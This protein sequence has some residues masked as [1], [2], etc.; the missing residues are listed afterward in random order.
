[1]MPFDLNKYFDSVRQSLFAGTMNQDQVD[2]QQA[3][4]D[5]WA[6]RRAGDDMRWLAYF[7]ATA[8]H[9]TS[10]EM[11]P[12]EE[13]GKGEGQPYGEEDPDTGECYYGRGFVQL[14][15][16]DNY[17]RADDEVGCSSVNDPEQQLQ[18]EISGATGYIGMVEGW[19]R[20]DKLSDYFSASKDDPYGAREII[21]GDKD[22]VPSWSNGESI[23]Q[24]IAEYHVHFL[25]AL[26]LSWTAPD[27]DPGTVVDIAVNLDVTAPPG[28][29][30]RWTINGESFNDET[31]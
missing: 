23:G 22:I 14:T 26:N 24:L 20:G 8:Y 28:V 29:T 4:L 10:Q 6:A 25:E 21:N 19:F 30:I 5:G 17:Q 18:A 13:Y 9:E 31:T 12:I 15:W 3:I 27:P 1:M 16:K 2:G 11:Q 7:L